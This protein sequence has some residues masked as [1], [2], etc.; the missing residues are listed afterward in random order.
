V[1]KL[2]PA[3]VI[4]FLA[5]VLFFSQDI[6]K[7]YPSLQSLSQDQTTPHASY[8]LVDK[9]NNETLTH[10][11]VPLSVGDEYI[12]SNNRVFRITKIIKDKAYVEQIK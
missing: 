7:N 5:I 6:T 10:T 9:A 3:L 8:W 2:R 4:L 1:K 12:D 11:S